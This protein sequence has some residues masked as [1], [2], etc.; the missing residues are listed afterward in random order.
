MK[1]Y[2]FSILANQLNDLKALAD[3]K[4]KEGVQSEISQILPVIR[5]IKD[6]LI[7]FYH[8]SRGFPMNLADITDEAFLEELGRRL[9]SGDIKRDW[10]NH[11]ENCQ[12]IYIGDTYEESIIRLELEDFK[13]EKGYLGSDETK[14][15][16]E[17]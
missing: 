13:L 7:T 9:K 2:E 3:K 14:E 10:N 12:T 4:E 8:V 16:E 5:T 6:M 1:H 11:E 15:E 17:E